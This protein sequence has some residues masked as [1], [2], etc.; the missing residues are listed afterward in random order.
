L[1]EL[2]ININ[3]AGRAYPLLINA[4]EEEIIRQAGKIINEKLQ[5]FSEQFSVKDNQDAIAMFALQYVTDH[6]KQKVHTAEEDK[7]LNNRLNE[8]LSTL[9][10][11]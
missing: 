1:N 9:H 3:I 8:V 5:F 4:S 10:S 11:V 6:L 2:S 7:R